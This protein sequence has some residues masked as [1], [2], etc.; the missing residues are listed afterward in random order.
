MTQF[1][2][3]FALLGFAGFAIWIG[4]TFLTLLLFYWIIRLAVRHGL[5][6]HAKDGGGSVGRSGGPRDW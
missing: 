5:R 1:S 4:V 6:D 3:D 2:D